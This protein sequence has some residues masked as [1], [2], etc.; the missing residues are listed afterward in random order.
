M[1][2]MDL[3]GFILGVFIFAVGGITGCIA[4]DMGTVRDCAT[5]GVMV[6]NSVRINC[7]IVKVKP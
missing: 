6:A 4:V 5:K 1:M 3:G 2:E 7:E